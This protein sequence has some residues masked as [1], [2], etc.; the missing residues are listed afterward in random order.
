VESTVACARPCDIPTTPVARVLHA[1]AV[2][3]VTMVA[4]SM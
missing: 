3:L 2:P 1:S 4:N